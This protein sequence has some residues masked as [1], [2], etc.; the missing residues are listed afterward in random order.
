MN[1]PSLTLPLWFHQ[2]GYDSQQASY[3]GCVSFLAYSLWN[4]EFQYVGVVFPFGRLYPVGDIWLVKIETH[5]S[6]TE[7]WS[8][9][10]LMKLHFGSTF[11][12]V[13]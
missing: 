2:W 13:P 8:V 11:V 1:R 5:P 6:C 7:K 9:D 10:L 4:I 12:S 3:S